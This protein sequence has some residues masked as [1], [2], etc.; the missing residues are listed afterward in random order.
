MIHVGIVV[1]GDHYSVGELASGQSLHGFLTFGGR[2]VLHEDLQRQKAFGLRGALKQQESTSEGAGRTHLPAAGHLH[3]VH[4]PGD[5][6]GAHA[7]V[8]AALLADVLQDL[9]VVLVVHQLLGHHHVEEAQHL[10]GH[11]RVLQPLQPRDLQR[12]RG[13]DDGRLV[14]GNDQCYY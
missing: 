3:A 2:D 8:L 5:L 12:H 7:A 13:L 6:D 1:F 4:G 14:E 9:L 11:S 10:G